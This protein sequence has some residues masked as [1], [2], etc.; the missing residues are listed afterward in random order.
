M[1][2]AINSARDTDVKQNQ[3]ILDQIHLKDR[4]Y[5]KNE[6]DLQDKQA[7]R[8]KNLVKYNKDCEQASLQTQKTENTLK[9]KEV[10]RYQ[11][12]EKRE[13]LEKELAELTEKNL[14]EQT[15]NY[16]L[17]Y[18][19]KFLTQKSTQAEK[20]LHMLTEKIQFMT[21][22]LNK[23][24]KE[25]ADRANQIEVETKEQAQELQRQ[26]TEYRH[27]ESELKKLEDSNAKIKQQK[28]DEEIEKLSRKLQ[29]IE[30]QRTEMQTKLQNSHGEWS[31]K[32]QVYVTD[33]SAQR[34]KTEKDVKQIQDLLA[35]MA[36]V[37]EKQAQLML[38]RQ[39]LLQ[40]NFEQT[41]KQELTN[42]LH[43]QIQ[44]LDQM[45]EDTKQQIKE[46][47]D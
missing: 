43:A 1:L 42:H 23:Q 18:R 27:K 12:Q 20:R 40:D 30:R 45:I 46:I 32:L 15:T 33:I 11:E 3:G 2:K 6:R 34:E 38:Q 26:Q 16:Q 47:E 31:A 35:S 7:A 9:E 37:S 17:S 25:Q 8:L 24:I 21:S 28:Y 4:E 39:T 14:K 22:T 29:N 44:D 13:A 10:A 41:E 19:H 5:D 36:T